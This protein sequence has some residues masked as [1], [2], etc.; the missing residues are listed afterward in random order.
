MSCP[1]APLGPWIPRDEA[2]HNRHFGPLIGAV[3]GG[4]CGR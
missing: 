2:I 3:M 1:A 4:A